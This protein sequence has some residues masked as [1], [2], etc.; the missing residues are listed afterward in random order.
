MNGIYPGRGAVL[1]LG[2]V[3]WLG[4]SASVGWSQTNFNSAQL[5]TGQWGGV[6][7]DNTGVVPD[8]G[9]PSHGG[10][11]P[12]HPLWYKWVAPESG[13][14]T[15]DTIGSVDATGL[16]L[17][18]VVAVYIGS[19]ISHLIQVAANDDYY[20]FT[21]IVVNTQTYGNAI[22]NP[23]EYTYPLPLSGP[24]IL[25]F[26]ATAG[27]T[28]YIA[29]DAM[30]GKGYSEVTSS[31]SWLSQVAQGPVALN[32]AFRPSG[33]VRFATEDYDV[34]GWAYSSGTQAMPLPLY[35]C[36]TYETPEDGCVYG[37]ES[38]YGTCY[39]YHPPGVLVTVTRVAGSCGRLWVDY[40][41]ADISSSGA[42]AFTAPVPATAGVDYAPASGTLVFDDFEMT[43]RIVIPITPF[44]GMYTSTNNPQDH[45]TG[46][47]VDQV[48]HDFQVILSNPRLDPYETTNVPPPRLDTP[49]ATAT[50]RI[51]S[52]AGLG[53]DPDQNWTGTP[54][55]TAPS[56]DVYNFTKRNYRVARDVNNYYTP[57]LIEVDR[58]HKRELTGS[59]SETISFRVNGWL[60]A[61]IPPININNAFTLNPGSDYAI[62]D[63]ADA[64]FAIFPSQGGE[65]I[66]TNHDFT[67]GDGTITIPNNG[68]AVITFLVNNDQLTKFNKEFTITLYQT[69]SGVNYTVG[70]N[71]ECHVTILFADEHP[72]AG[73]VDEYYNTDFGGDMKPPVPSD[74]DHP[75]TDGTVWALAVQPDD[76]AIIAGEFATYNT[77]P[78]SCIARAM[79]GG[80]FDT[81]FDV[82]TG[83]DDGI[84]SSLA[85]LP[86]GSGS[87]M[88]GGTFNY[89]NASY[90]PFVARLTSTGG[91]DSSFAPTNFPDGPVWAL[92]IG[93]SNQVTI[94]GDFLNIGSVP[95]AHVARYNWDGSLDPTF[96]PS[97]N[98]PT[99]GSVSCLALQTDGKV[100][101]GGSFA[102]LGSQPLAGLAR[103]NADGSADTAFNAN[104]GFGVNG[105]VQTVVIQGGSKIVF[106][107]EFQNVGVAQRNRIARLNSDGTIDSTFN[108]GGGADDTI[109]NISAQ[110]D[111]TMY[112]GGLFTMFNGTHRLGFT[113]LYAD[114]TVDTT[115]LDTAYNQFAG[116]HRKYY[117]KQWTDPVNPDP[118]PDPRPF[119]AASQVLPDG[120][121]V[122][123]GSFSQVGGGQADASIRFDSD[124]P[125]SSIDTNVWTEPKSRD[126]V[127]NRDNFA[128]L[129][130][131]ATPGPGSIGLLYTNYTVNRSQGSLKVD[132]IRTN[133][134]LGY[135]SANFA[136][137][138]GLAQSGVDYVYNNVPPLYI[139]SWW[140]QD[141][142]TDPYYSTHPY[143]STRAHS[144][145]YYL[146]N[147]V[148]T[149]VY[150][151]IWFPYANPGP[152]TL[153]LTIEN[154]GV[155]GNVGTQVQMAN[156]SG[157]DQFFLGGED[158]PLGNALGVSAAPFTIVDDSHTPGV[159]GFAFANFYVNENGTNAVITITRTN[160]SSG[161][162]AVSFSTVDGTG[163]VGSN[164]VAPLPNPLRITFQP[165]QTSTNVSVKILDDGI[166]EPSG[167]TV[168]LRLTGVSGATLG[169]AS[170]TLNIL[171]TD[172]TPGYLTFS[173]ASYVT[174][175]SGGAVILEV[176]RRQANKGTLS[177]Q[178]ITTDGTAFNGTNYLG[179]TNTLSW[180]DGDPVLARYVT[181]PLIN[182]GLVG[183]NTTF[184]VYLTN[185]V[186]NTNTSVPYVL[187]NSPTSA[188][189]TIVDDNSYGKLQFSAPSYRV[190]ENG[191]YTTIPVIRTGGSSGSL[192]VTCSTADGPLASATGPLPN[193][194]ATTN[195]LTFGP[196]VVAT[197]FTVPILDDGVTNGAPSNF[198]FSVNLSQPSQPGTLGYPSSAQ[199][200][201]V[202]A[203]SFIY[204][205]GSPD[206][207]DPDPGFNGDVFGVALQTN[208]QIVAVGDFTVVN[209]YPRSGIARLNTDSTIDTAFLNQLAGA[210]GPIQTLLIQ[211]DGRILAG[212]PFTQVNNLNRNGLARLMSDGTLDSSF[213]S[214]AG[215]DNE[216]YAFAETFMPD[217]RILVGGSF[218]KM[219]GV[220]HPG[221]ARLNNAGALDSTFNPNL[222][223]NGT[224]YAIA[225]YPTNT[226][227]GGKIMIGGSFT[228]VNGVP[229]PGVARLYSD[230][231]LDLAFDPGTGATNAVRALA[232]QL[233]GRVLVGGSFTNFNGSALNH[234]ARLNVNVNGQVDGQVD[235]SFNVGAGAD[236]TVDAIVVQPDTRILLVGLFTHANGVS[237]NRITRLLP[238]G[239]VDPAIN[240][241]LGADSYIDSI[242]LQ[243]DGMLMVIGGG[244][245]TYDGQPRP[246]L[247]RVYGGSLAGSGLFTFTSANFQA[248][249]DSG[250][251][252]LSVRRTGGTAGNMT[253]GFATVGL[254]AQPG[255]NFVNVQTN[256]VFPV[257]ETFLSVQVPLIH[258]F[259]IT[260]DLIVSNY[261]F[262][263]SP[264]AGLGSQYY[265]YLT[266]LNDDSTVSFS[267]DSYSVYQNAA[268][269]SN[270]F[271][272]DVVRTGSTRSNAFVNF[273]TTT[274]GTAVA[275]VD[276]GAITNELLTIPPGTTDFS[277]PIL[278]LNNPFSS[279]DTT[280]VMQLSNAIN[281]TL[282][283]P[284]QA[285]LTILTTNQQ[286]GQFMFSQPSYTVSEGAGSLTATVLRVN[287]H[288]DTVTV[289]FGTTNGTAQAGLMY[290]A[291][292]GTLTF[293]DLETSKS[294]P[295][296]ILETHQ[297]TGNLTFSL[298][299][300]NPQL[301]ATLTS[302]SNAQVTIVD[303][304]V[305]VYFVNPNPVV[306]ETSGNVSLTVYRQNGTN[307]VTTVHYSTTNITAQAGINYVGVANGIVTF[308]PGIV[309][310][311]IV[312][313]VIHDPLVTG[314]LKF[315]VN[316][317]N[318]S[319]P[320]QLGPASSA[321]VVLLDVES[322]ISIASTN[323]IAVTNADLSVTT[324]A[325]FGVFKSSGTNLPITIVV[326]NVNNGS[327]G[328]NYATADG[329]ALAGVDYVTNSGSLTLGN[330]IASQI[331]GV[332]IVSN[333]LIEGD[334][335]FTFYLTNATPTN[336][337]S[338]LIPYA[339]TVTITDDTAGLSFSS[340]TYMVN[341]NNK[342]GVGISVVRNNY[343][344]NSVRVD[345][346]T[347][348]GSGQALVNYYPTN[349]TLYFT[350][351]E[352]VK[353]FVVV[354]KDNQILDGN[355]TVQ[356]YLS[357]AVNTTAGSAVLVNPANATLL[358]LET[359]GSLIIPAGVA[360]IY[361]SGPVNDVIDPGETVT[362]LFGLRNA[363]GTNTAN[364]VA[365][366]LATN[367]VTYPSG[368][369]T[370]GVLT[371][372]GPSVSRPFTFTANAT[373]GQTINAI[374]QLTDGSTV[375]SNAVF[376]FSVGKTPATYAN[377]NAIVIN[378]DA[379]A[380]PYPSVIT[381]SNLNG[382]VTQ[383]TVTLTNLSHPNPRD[384][385]A[386]LVSPTGQ[387]VLLMSHC[388]GT[389]LINNV[390]LTFDDTATNFLP[391]FTLITN[392]TYRCTPYDTTPPF[393]PPSAPFPT[394]AT[395]A[396]YATNLSIF[397][398]TSP[399][400]SW[401]LYVISDDALF[402]GS[403]ANGWMI[404]LNLTGPIPGSADL[405]LGMSASA[406]TV[407]A[408]SNLTYTVSVTNAGPSTA[409]NVVVTDTLP[410]G[411]VLAATNPTQGSVNN[412][413][414]MVTWNVGS[415]AYGATASLGLTVQA[416]AAGTLTNSAIVTSA[417]PDPNPD[418]NS[419][420]VT[421]TVI[422]P[423][424][425]LALAMAD[426]PDPVLL[427]YNLTYTLTVNNL[428]PATASG[429]TLVDTLPPTVSFVSA[430]PGNAFARVGQVVTFNLGNLGS[431]GQTTAT[432]VVQPTALGTP[433][434]SAVCS[435]TVTDPFKANNHA[436]VKTIVQQVPLTLASVKGG[437][438]ISWPASFNYILQS[439]TNLHPPAV[440]M[441]VTDIMPV[442]T[443][444]Q[445]VVVVPIGPGNQFFRLAYSPVPALPLSVSRAGSNLKLAWPTNSW[446]ASLESAASLRMPVVWNPVT[447][448]LPSVVGGQNTLTLP[449]GGG[450]QYFRLHGTAP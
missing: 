378:D 179:G 407:I 372:G 130:G 81:S 64:C 40:T 447:S 201:I 60:A 177:V 334:R 261:L 331:V 320:A 315:G 433:L 389:M 276:Y 269:T 402:S 370:Y 144:D 366:L 325:S 367:G 305:G 11:R 87:M 26:N 196:G 278:V 53:S 416:G 384:I 139:G 365:T 308:Q 51:M 255:T 28:Y 138:P 217:R 46:W 104:L 170:A 52:S 145:G 411:A 160:G 295:V 435:S 415:L 450:P 239:T 310:T 59:R 393:P 397:N 405:A 417:T 245:S 254:T 282:T 165:G 246:H 256:L 292:N 38:T 34:D 403:I 371:T 102:N 199:V 339:A 36:T 154:S 301:G 161:S 263:P 431:N 398:G 272:V 50:V 63:P 376:S 355:H 332:Q 20:P 223:V 155:A 296:Q 193:Y 249:E 445:M 69:V 302:V 33:V 383:V 215:G 19:D 186:W 207:F 148:P 32:W 432:I 379:P 24:S 413:A 401:A 23:D 358:I 169:L 192:I 359:D 327:L 347:A 115:F 424:A 173:S 277:V 442:Q 354:P 48:D 408:T 129:I 184:G 362:L 437:L 70:E 71:A 44:G 237:R 164:Y 321:T 233:D 55:N 444:G 112:V 258:D 171:D 419:A 89:F 267:T 210:N 7:N 74:I 9:G 172:L 322:G 426:S 111:G 45:P 191:G 4:V 275:G 404:N 324:N 156:P 141:T 107:G 252:V 238:D 147:T 190:S 270:L 392:G 187:G 128:R 205:A 204:P 440:W 73:S 209:N 175:V 222:S 30:P 47:P 235:A 67:M 244:F 27:T 306:P 422:P 236:D 157:A 361:E 318:P 118:V 166:S 336:V 37:T 124:Y 110:P 119:V 103:L 121:V 274:N 283:V 162:P 335:S 374:L 203:E 1:R 242:A 109:Y 213:N 197:N 313:G 176:D 101:I 93:P 39:T 240:F 43:K 117:D 311:N 412:A 243:P 78:S 218:L 438:E 232:I 3:A 229:R 268:G 337:A 381:L 137:Q 248:D 188:T 228:A 76:K 448:P 142:V 56:H 323:L 226:I 348:D 369:Q 259:V 212:G 271:Y 136:L 375:L 133:G 352:T 420:S 21:H 377:S 387:K 287:G 360:L 66:Y 345:F 183:P 400:G 29:V 304:N 168:G 126:G 5:I 86:D 98:A 309:F 343:T 265:A 297:V 399:N 364:L 251:A 328:V 219:N 293:Q 394:N 446:N 75:G 373:N 178:C 280:V 163:H 396:P 72:P 167:L 418:D 349:G 382:L 300:S 368:P 340:P 330:G 273:F 314:D 409:T 216:V 356:L 206:G 290:V 247:A 388:G 113:R 195:T 123:G 82:G 127:R 250:N 425:D 430:S 18:T 57:V 357:N 13:E 208:G 427:G 234:I 262:N 200:Y 58:T 391:E 198:W 91:L 68:C 317:F 299:L 214:A 8:S 423:T 90:T 6:T 257:G 134:V 225:V 88:I 95:R 182:N 303:D 434:N 333:Q 220:S 285:S 429:V 12:L 185:A 253:V 436:S 338:L 120:N 291:T 140:P 99:N 116:L 410:A 202:D 97:A 181:I 449:I 174:N 122:I 326:S 42:A 146:S 94:V 151:H 441:P 230:G 152:G 260:P 15:L 344:N 346:F 284:S 131:G 289:D 341:E 189:V 25:R 224:V 279:N 350:N 281:S 380:T 158:I 77:I 241:G 135:A 35:Q 17:D 286:P 298:L 351:G 390:T 406:P 62:P 211:T 385:D 316:L 132:V 31:F 231:T 153:T 41:T 395:A 312:I 319:A 16:N 84:I 386:L 105:V 342:Q 443:N 79:P 227:Q 264:P 106:G 194:I 108:T 266:I 150:G 143:Y 439:T 96:D 159:I 329:T 83:C 421:T 92:A 80:S 85:L 414:G 294:F 49:F 125:Y 100:V 180:S 61:S 114:G 428:G 353:S 14:V 221:L 2:L 363:N 307:G 10:F 288:H 54:D 22:N 65:L 149:D